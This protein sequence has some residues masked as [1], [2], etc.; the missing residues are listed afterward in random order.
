M[1]LRRAAV[2]V[3]VA[4]VAFAAAF[5]AGRGTRTHHRALTPPRVEQFVPPARNPVTPNLDAAGAFP[6]LRAARGVTR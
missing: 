2:V 6:S 3:A 1:T 5:A 4:A